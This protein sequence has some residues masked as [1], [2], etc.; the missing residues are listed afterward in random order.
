MFIRI[1][2]QSTLIS[3]KCKVSQGD[4]MWSCYVVTKFYELPGISKCSFNHKFRVGTAIG[5]LQAR[6]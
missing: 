5:A 6:Q 4:Y 2:A 1:Q 3:V